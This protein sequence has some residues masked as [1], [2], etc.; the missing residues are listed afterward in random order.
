MR[1]NVKYPRTDETF[2]GWFGSYVSIAKDNLNK[3]YRLPFKA[4]KKVKLAIF[5]HKLY[6]TF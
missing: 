6:T 5:Q 3:I 1:N 2:R 4:T